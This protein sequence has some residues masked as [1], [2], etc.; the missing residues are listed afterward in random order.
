[1][2]KSQ[3][4]MPQ[5]YAVVFEVV[6]TADVNEYKLK[7]AFDKRIYEKEQVQEETQVV[8]K[9]LAKVMENAEAS[10]GAVLGSFRS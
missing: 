10:V 8:E 2:A 5:P 6:K 7:F 9:L 3:V 4:T 1:M